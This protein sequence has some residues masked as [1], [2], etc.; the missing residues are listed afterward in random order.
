MSYVP[1]AM[2]TNRSSTIHH[3]PCNSIKIYEKIQ[4]QVHKIFCQLATLAGYLYIRLL[5]IISF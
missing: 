1:N 5:A 2:K 3:A 4:D